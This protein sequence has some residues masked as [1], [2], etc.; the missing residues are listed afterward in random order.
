[1][2]ASSRKQG[3]KWRPETAPLDAYL[4]PHQAA[5]SGQVRPLRFSTAAG[6]LGQYLALIDAQSPRSF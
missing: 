1:M 5:G 2:N 4:T 6:K 3:E